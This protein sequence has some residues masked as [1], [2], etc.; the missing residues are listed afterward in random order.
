MQGQGK[1][2]NGLLRG[3]RMGSQEILRG[4]GKIL[5]NLNHGKILLIKDAIGHS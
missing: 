1:Y 5:F 4:N 3:Q 2:I